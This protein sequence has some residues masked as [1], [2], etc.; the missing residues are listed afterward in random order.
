[1][2]DLR[3]E[4]RISVRGRTLGGYAT[5]SLT[6]PNRIRLN[7]NTLWSDL[8]KQIQ[9]LAARRHTEPHVALRACENLF[10]FA[11]GVNASHEVLH[12][13][14]HTIPEVRHFGS[15]FR[16]ADVHHWALSR[17]DRYVWGVDD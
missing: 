3:I 6:K 13:L 2:Q 5:W 15:R 11:F 8:Y 10:A 12:C 14:L 7:A 9:I 1:V 17:I 4:T 16:E